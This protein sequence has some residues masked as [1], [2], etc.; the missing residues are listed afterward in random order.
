MKRIKS[1]IIIERNKTCQRTK[2][3]SIKISSNGP[4]YN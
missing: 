3:K 4:I 2:E 1:A